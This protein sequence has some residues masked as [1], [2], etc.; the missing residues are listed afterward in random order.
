MRSMRAVFWSVLCLFSATQAHAQ[1]VSGSELEEQLQAFQRRADGTA[2]ADDAIAIATLSGYLQGI[3][4]A[5]NGSAFCLAR[6]VTIGQEV[7]IVQRFMAAN[8]AQWGLPADTLI[9]RA[10]GRALPCRRR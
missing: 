1:F 7:Q 2:L 10:L 6:H 8:Q 9:T 4:D 5:R 3:S